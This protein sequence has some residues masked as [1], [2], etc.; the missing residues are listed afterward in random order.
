MLLTLCAAY[1]ITG[2]EKTHELTLSYLRQYESSTDFPSSA[3]STLRTLKSN[4]GG[5]LFPDGTDNC[6]LG[7]QP[8]CLRLRP[9]P[10]HP[11]ATL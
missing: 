4:S 1:I 9:G 2:P 3:E 11:L 7:H 8:G 10:G 6:K 5:E